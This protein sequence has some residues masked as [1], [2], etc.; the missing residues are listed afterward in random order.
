MK[1]VM[2]DPAK[3][4]KAKYNPRRK[5]KPGDR[6]YE[7]I[8][9]SLT[10]FGLVQPLVWNK[11]TKRLVGGEQR[12][13]VLTDMGVQSVPV[14]EV[15]L[16]ERL[17]KGLNIALNKVQGEWDEGL[18]SALLGELDTEV[19]SGFS[20]EEIEAITKY[21]EPDLGAISDSRE[22][23]T[24]EIPRIYQIVLDCGDQGTQ[25]AL[26]AEFKKRK[27]AAKAVVI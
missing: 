15:D 24:A 3:I 11:K 12:L 10:K 18:L 25:D 9:S 1:I 22:P 4:T 8:K 13:T 5:L 19:F 21:D 17:E 23:S 16:E 2:M 14:V 26:M 6:E 20:P 7:D 27:I